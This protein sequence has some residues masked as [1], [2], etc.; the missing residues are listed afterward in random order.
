MMGC[1]AGPCRAAC[2]ARTGAASRLARSPLIGAWASWRGPLR[3]TNLFR[4]RSLALR[5]GQDP[6]IL[7]QPGEI[8]RV[9]REI[10]S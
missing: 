9:Y 8:L 10:L 6:A 3:L 7:K 1:A 2:E 4:I 5:P